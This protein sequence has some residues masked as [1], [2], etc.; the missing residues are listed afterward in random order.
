MRKTVEL[1]DIDM[2]ACAY[3]A[4]QDNTQTDIARELGLSQT[5]V[6]RLLKEARN[7]GYLSVKSLF[8]EEKIGDDLLPKVRQRVFNREIVS[9]LHKIAEHYSVRHELVLRVFSSGSKDSSDEGMKIRI[10]EFS[11]LA[12]PL[13]KDLLMNIVSCGVSWGTTLGGVV[14]ALSKALTDAPHAKKPITV[15]PL[16]GEPLGPVPNS[17]SSSYLAADLGKMLNGGAVRTLSLS[18]VPA[19][20]PGDFEDKELDVVWKMIGLVEAY[21]QIFDSQHEQ[22]PRSEQEKSLASQLEMILTSIGPAESLFGYIGRELFRS[23]MKIE[24]LQKVAFGDI[25][26][27]CIPRPGISEEGEKQLQIIAERWTGVRRKHLEDC[28]NR[29]AKLKKPGVVVVA[30][31]KKKAQFVL[32][33][34]KHGLVNILIVDDDLEEHLK[35]LVKEELS[36]IH[37]AA[38]TLV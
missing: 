33:I 3:L 25:C 32:E 30:V 9:S 17:Y 2:L 31:G 10:Q 5:T 34:V 37:S 8:H 1:A 38:Q 4:S 12:A 16:G 6:S 15:I 24:E 22:S 23:G 21:E 28:A 11:R 27:V 20:I 19:F 26:G 36:A 29:A 14:T 13:I 7:R 35:L 18:M